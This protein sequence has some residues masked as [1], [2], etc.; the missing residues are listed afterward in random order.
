MTTCIYAAVMC[1]HAVKQFEP[2]LIAV[3]VFKYLKL[4]KLHHVK[5]SVRSELQFKPL[6]GN[7]PR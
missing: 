5:I 6:T 7:S 1:S 4:E 3:H 2:K